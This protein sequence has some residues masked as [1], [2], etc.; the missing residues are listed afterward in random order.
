VVEAIKRRCAEAEPRFDD[1]QNELLATVIE[2]LLRERGHR[3]APTNIQQKVQD[4]VEL[5]G[6]Q[7]W[8]RSEAEA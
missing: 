5:L 4:Q 7:V 2:I 3:V 1:Y 8:R 6:D